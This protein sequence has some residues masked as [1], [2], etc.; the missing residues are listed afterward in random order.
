MAFHPIFRALALRYTS[1]YNANVMPFSSC[2]GR[3]YICGRRVDPDLLHEQILA[4]AYAQ[5]NE[6]QTA[7]AWRTFETLR[8]AIETMHNGHPDTALA[9]LGNLEE[10]DQ[11]LA[12]ELVMGPASPQHAPVA[13][14]LFQ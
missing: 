13:S 3:I 4:I 2:Q 5:A 7:E 9:I 14:P 8:D 12:I 11:A 1:P 6:S 10:A